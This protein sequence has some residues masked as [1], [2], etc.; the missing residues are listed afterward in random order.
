MVD[1]VFLTR[2]QWMSR[3]D[4]GLFSA[5]LTRPEKEMQPKIFSHSATARFQHPKLEETQ[6]FP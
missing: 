5:Q 1:R 4:T 6:P 2:Q 3:L